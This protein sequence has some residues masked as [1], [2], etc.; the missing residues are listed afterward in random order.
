MSPVPRLRL[1]SH[2]SGTIKLIITSAGFLCGIMVRLGPVLSENH[3]EALEIIMAT[4]RAVSIHVS[5]LTPT[6]RKN[7]LK[8]GY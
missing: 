1:A 7:L 3:S 8:G 4:A 5:K 2:L 6:T